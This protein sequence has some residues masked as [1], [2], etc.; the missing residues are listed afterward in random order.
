MAETI[1][2]LIIPAEIHAIE[3]D[4]VWPFLSPFALPR[5][6]KLNFRRVL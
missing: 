2:E 3:F 1:N 5:I 6:P 4:E